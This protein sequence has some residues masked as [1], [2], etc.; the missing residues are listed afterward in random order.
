MAE[1]VVVGA[2]VDGFFV[3]A[4]V[5]GFVGVDVGGAVFWHSHLSR[6]LWNT[7]AHPAL[8]HVTDFFPAR[9]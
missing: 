8:S 7:H 1:H 4:L 9:A 2:A 5:V 3:G 6:C